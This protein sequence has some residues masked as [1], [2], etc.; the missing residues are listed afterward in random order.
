MSQASSQVTQITR[1]RVGLGR[2]FPGGRRLCPL[3]QAKSLSPIRKFAVSLQVAVCPF[4][5]RILNPNRV[6]APAMGWL[7]EPFADRS[8]L[9]C[10]IPAGAACIAL[11][12][13]LFPLIIVP[14]VSHP[15]INPANGGL[16]TGPIHLVPCY[17][18]SPFSGRKTASCPK[19]CVLSAQASPRQERPLQQTSRCRTLCTISCI[20]IIRPEIYRVRRGEQATR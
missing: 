20:V 18:L 10:R 13:G 6:P 17:A 16:C 9:Q 3:L 4:D 8:W 5:S 2:V 15:M 7:H 11:G 19:A 1:L 12:S 14:G